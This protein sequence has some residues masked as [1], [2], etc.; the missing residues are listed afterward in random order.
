VAYKLDVTGSLSGQTH[1]CAQRCRAATPVAAEQ[2]NQFALIDRQ[3]YS[4]RNVRVRVERMEVR[5]LKY[6]GSDIIAPDFQF[7]VTDSAKAE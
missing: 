1:D 2:A 4:V 7:D 3:F 5:H 6:V